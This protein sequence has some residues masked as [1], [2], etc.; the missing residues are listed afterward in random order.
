MSEIQAVLWEVVDG[1]LREL[2]EQFSSDLGCYWD[3]RRIH[4]AQVEMLQVWQ[5][6][7]ARDFCAPC[8]AQSHDIKCCDMLH[9][10]SPIIHSMY[11]A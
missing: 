6:N 8:T 11:A 10:V 3:A 1:T 9:T 5:M 7:K 4:N 2:R